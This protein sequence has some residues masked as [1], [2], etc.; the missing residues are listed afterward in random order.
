[1]IKL[2][3]KIRFGQKCNDYLEDKKVEKFT[4]YQPP[5]S[6]EKLHAKFEISSGKFFAVHLGGDM[7]GVLSGLG[8]QEKVS[9]SCCYKICF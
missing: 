2:K 1:M 6:L 9:K 4:E 5:Q 3:G 8:V 7:S